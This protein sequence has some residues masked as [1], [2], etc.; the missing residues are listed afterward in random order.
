MI[1]DFQSKTKKMKKSASIDQNKIKVICDQLCDRIEDLLDSL[2][3]EYRMNNKFISMSCPIHG[4]DNIGAINLY[5][6][7]DNYRGNWKC[8]THNCEEIFKGSIIGFIRGVLS[9]RNHGWCKHG[10]D[11]CSFEDALNYATSFLNVSLKDIKISKTS[12]DKSLFV[13]NSKVLSNNIPNTDSGI[14]RSIVRKSLDIPSKYFLSRGFSKEILDK[15]DV[16]DCNNQ[17]KEMYERA[18]VPIYNNEYSGM[19]GCTGR[20][21]FDKCEKCKAFHNPDL[22]CPQDEY[23][24]K[25]SKWKHNSGFKTQESLYNF[26]FAKDF[27]RDSGQVVLVESPG[28][29][30]KLEENNIHNSVALFGAH[31]TD[32]QKTILDTS[33][34]MSLIVIMDSDEAGDNARK[35]IYDK[36]HRIYN[37]H[38]IKVSKNDIA[39]MTAEEIDKEIKRFL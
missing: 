28:N 20:S 11:A 7:G 6:N 21:L 2:D 25:Q 29:V 36:C 30:W 23:A 17:N 26:W 13:N 4:G 16:G 33:G 14:N 32:R 1:L 34:A 10:D 39:D 22:K 18:V 3:L 31:L 27:I 37:I 12:K 38:N 9:H 24:W 15:Y 5:H 19:I 35:Q 8:R